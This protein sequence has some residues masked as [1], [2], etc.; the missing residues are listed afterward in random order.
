M[1]DMNSKPAI[2]IDFENAPHVWVLS[3]IIRNL[4]EK[5]YPIVLTA[6]EFSYTVGLCHRLGYDV[7]VVGLPGFGK[8]R[9]AKI[10]RVLERAWRLYARLSGARKRIALALSHGSRSQILAAHYLGIPVVS[11]DDYEFSDQTL[12]RFVDRLL[13][14][15]AIP[16]ETWGCHADKITHY[17]GAKEELYLCRFVPNEHEIEE[18]GAHDRVRVLFRPE[19][20]FAHYRSIH[21]QILQDAVLSH[22]GKHRNILVTLLPRDVVQARELSDLCIAHAISYWIPKQVLDG[23]SLIWA[24]D[25]VIG[26][27]GTMTREAA[28]LGVPAYSFFAGEWGAVDCYLQAQGRLVRLIDTEDVGK[29]RLEK[30]GRAAVAVPDAA[31]EFVTGFIDDILASGAE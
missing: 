30:R 3:P 20:R 1:N 16:K 21:R 26:G 14:P 19:G 10:G 15:L 23:P 29:I 22:L 24:M 9:V 13:V 8:N 17:P 2:W 11:L 12:M 6:R 7:Q 28:T 5:G 25:A 31:L 4:R 18:L 27:G